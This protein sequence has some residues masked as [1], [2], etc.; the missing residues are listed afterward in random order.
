MKIPSL[1]CL[2]AAVCL[3]NFAIAGGGYQKAQDGKTLVWN[4]N[5]QSGD[6]ATWS[7]KRDSSGYAIGRGTLTWFHMQK[8]IVT[9][10]NLPLPK[11]SAIASYT[12][13]MVRGKLNGA[14][15]ATDANGKKFHGTYVAGRRTKWNA[16]V[17]KGTS[18]P[19]EPLMRRG[20]LVEPPAQGP[21][22]PAPQAATAPATGVP[23]TSEKPN[24]EFDDSLRSLVGPP[25][26]MRPN[27]ETDARSTWITPF[28]CITLAIVTFAGG[29]D[30]AR[31][32]HLPF[33]A[34]NPP[35]RSDEF[36]SSSK[37]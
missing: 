1:I 22:E 21:I 23:P 29:R 2:A 20:E 11:Y 34:L 24:G 18:P 5:P 14:I 16:G 10:S 37:S 26:G 32:E 13:E 4:S 35:H 9:G 19:N 3:T 30:I 12:G 15:V 36:R 6:S 7:G 33:A 27:P 25:N 31:C 17:A 8:K 28:D